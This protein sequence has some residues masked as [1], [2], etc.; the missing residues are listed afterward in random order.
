M[1]TMIIRQSGAIN[2]APFLVK[3]FVFSLVVGFFAAYVAAHTLALGRDYLQV[4]RVVG[5]VAFMAYGLGN[6]ANG[7]WKG[8]TWAW[9]SRKVSMGLM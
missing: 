8:E 1:G 5:S 2:L 7:I 3:R 9:L 6:L 4:F